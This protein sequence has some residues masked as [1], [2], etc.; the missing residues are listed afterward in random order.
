MKPNDIVKVYHDP[1]TG[2]D[3]EGEARL[4]YHH[5]DIGNGLS[6]WVVWFLHE[7]GT[8]YTRTINEANA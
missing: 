7:W 6:E 5:K 4:L 2:K 3:L 1:V 8:H